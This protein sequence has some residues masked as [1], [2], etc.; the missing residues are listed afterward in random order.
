MSKVFICSPSIG[1][2]LLWPC[3]DKPI[4]PRDGGTFICI[5]QILINFTNLIN[6]LNNKLDTL[7]YFKK[8]IYLFDILFN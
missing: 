8:N 7:K 2:S 1:S 4:S 6:I 5:I 3:K